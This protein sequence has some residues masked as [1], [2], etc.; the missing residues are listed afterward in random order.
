MKSIFS[1]IL[2]SCLVGLHACKPKN[3]DTNTLKNELSSLVD[4]WHL[5]AAEADEEVYFGLLSDESI[6]I[7]TDPKEKWDKTCY[8]CKSIF[9]PS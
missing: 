9:I 6:Y 2:I 7:G 4:K 5:A 1:L 8:Y 3:T